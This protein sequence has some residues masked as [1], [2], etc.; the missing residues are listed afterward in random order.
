M[1]GMNDNILWILMLAVDHLVNNA[2]G[3]PVGI[4]EHITDVTNFRP[5]MVISSLTL[6]SLLAFSYYSDVG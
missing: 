1:V 5:A 6:R 3:A 2:G 4:F